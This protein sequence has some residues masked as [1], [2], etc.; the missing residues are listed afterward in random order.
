[1][2]LYFARHG[3]SQANIVREISNRGLKHPLTR[4]GREQAVALA[5]RLR[6]LPIRRI[7]SSPVLRAIETT[8]IVAHRLD[9]E[10]EIVDALREYDCGLIEGRSDDEC[11]RLWRELF[12]DW[13]LHQRWDRCLEGGET[14]YN[15]RD[16]FVPFIEG[17]IRKHRESDD[18]WLCVAHGGLYWMMLPLVLNNVNTDLIARYQFD[19]TSCIV[20]ELR[21]EGLVCIEWN[22]V[23]I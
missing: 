5:D 18:N 6:G 14:F 13:V 17:L 16:R 9:L 7:Y 4:K 20:S 19:Y 12:D 11:H 8:I 10:Y 1:M 21:P 2:R 23:A 15:I 22:G 3:E